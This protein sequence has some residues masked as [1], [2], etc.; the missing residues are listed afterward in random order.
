M[1]FVRYDYFGFMFVSLIDAII[2][3]LSSFDKQTPFESS[4][5]SMNIISYKLIPVF[6]FVIIGL[7]YVFIIASKHTHTHTHKLK[8]THLMIITWLNY[9]LHLICHQ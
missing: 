3:L 4:R 2:I 1:I 5:F 9:N 7:N 8:N 6:C